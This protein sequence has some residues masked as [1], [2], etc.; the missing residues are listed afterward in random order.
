MPKWVDKVR[1]VQK[2]GIF[3]QNDPRPHEMPKQMFL[4]RFELVVARFGPPKIP[5]CLEN[6]LVRDKKWVKNAFFPKIIL[7]HL[8][9]M[10][11]C[12]EPI[13]RPLQAILATPKSQN[14]L[15]MGWFGTKSQSKMGQKN[16]FPKILLG[17]LGCANK[18]NE[19]ILR[20]C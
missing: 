19:P 20:P 4:A 14:A 8:G 16:V 6:G 17:H 9:C 18:W 2:N 5:K 3:F 11:K 7:D 12:N 10:N 1:L 13:L 15:N